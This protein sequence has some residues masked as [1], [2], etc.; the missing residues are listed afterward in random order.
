MQEQQRR[1]SGILMNEIEPQVYQTKR[2]SNYS[3][4]QYQADAEGDEQD[5]DV[6]ESG[7]DNLSH[8]DMSSIAYIDESQHMN[9]QS[10]D[11]EY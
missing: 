9:V 4:R 3:E 1:V 10:P 8:L 11:R 6:S 2:I 5:D 7:E